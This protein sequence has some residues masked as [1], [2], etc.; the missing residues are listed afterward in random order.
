MNVVLNEYDLLENLII[1]SLLLNKQDK[2]FF[3]NKK[4][5]DILYENFLQYAKLKLLR[6]KDIKENY[7][8]YVDLNALSILTESRTQREIRL[9]QESI[10]DSIK[11]AASSAYE[12][13]KGGVS[14]VL[15]YAKKSPA[16]LLQGIADVASIFDPTGL[17]DLING[18][19]YFGRG[20]ISSA[21][22]SFVGAAMVLPGF[23]SSLT[24]GGAVAG[25][26]MIAAGKAL[27]NILKFGGKLGAPILKFAA[28][29]MKAGGVVEK[30]LA[31]GAKIPGLGKFLE[32]IKNAVPKFVKAVEEGGTV[33]E[34]LSK[35]FGGKGSEVVKAVGNAGENL[36]KKGTEI[37]TKGA[38]TAATKT[39]TAAAE[40]AGKDI[41]KSAVKGQIT[42]AANKDAAEAVAKYTAPAKSSTFQKLSSV[43]NLA[44]TAMSA[45]SGQ[46]QQQSNTTNVAQTSRNTQTNTNYN[47]YEDEDY[48]DEEEQ[49]GEV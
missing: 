42:K 35:S 3:K 47:D 49:D 38:K 13:V 2:K 39:A 16:E 4:N 18:S 37:A 28:K 44:S 25:I 19:I 14:S 6:L 22:F 46:P 30:L 40:Q 29:A 27:K 24:V 31:T 45:A 41:T 1:E 5:L 8:N 17:V 34:I 23:L 12:A 9:I 33:T 32:F 20:E 26:P 7:K 36:V 43:G 10:W 48:N 21:F 11:S 15:D